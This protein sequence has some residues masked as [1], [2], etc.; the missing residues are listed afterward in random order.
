MRGWCRL[1]NCYVVNS[2]DSQDALCNAIRAMINLPYS[3]VRC[4]VSSQPA[5][6]GELDMT[7]LALAQSLHSNSCSPTIPTASGLADQE[8]A[9]RPPDRRPQQGLL[10]LAEHQGHAGQ[11]GGACG[12]YAEHQDP[13]R[14]PDC[15]VG[16]S[17]AVHAVWGAQSGA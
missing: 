1:K 15:R 3:P 5:C 4:S 11:A 10:P 6:A 9:G 12:N 14:Q 2:H 17:S 8:Q 7:C 13:D 16:S